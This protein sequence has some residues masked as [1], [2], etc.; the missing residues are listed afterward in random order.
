M[1]IVDDITIA[2]VMIV[3][4]IYLICCT[5]EPRHPND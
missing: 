5:I 1:M 2:T 3:V 4:T